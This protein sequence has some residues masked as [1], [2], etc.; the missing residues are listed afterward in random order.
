MSCSVEKWSCFS[1]AEWTKLGKNVKSNCL[2]KN[3]CNECAYHLVNI[4]QP[5]WWRSVCERSPRTRKVRC[6]NP[7]RNR[8][9]SLK[10]VVTAPLLYTQQQVWVSYILGDDYYKRMSEKFSKWDE[11]NH[12]NTANLKKENA[13]NLTPKK[14]TRIYM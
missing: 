4:S 12:I 13:H 11:K 5:R 9:K 14:T 8:S 2:F 1:F 6:S 3:T 10:Q 7:S